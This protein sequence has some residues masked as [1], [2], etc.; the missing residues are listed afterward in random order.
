MACVRRIHQIFFRFGDRRLQ[1]YPI[2]VASLDA[3]R[4]MKGWKHRLWHEKG[5]ERLCRTKYPQLWDTYRRLKF[6]I[7]RVDLAKYMLAD[8]YGGVIVDLDVLPKCHVSEIVG[9]RPYVF[10][11]C[12][13]AHIIANDF[14]YVGQQGLPGFCEAFKQNLRRVNAIPVYRERKMRYIFNSS[15]PDFF[16]RFVKQ[17]G[18]DEYVVAISHRTFLDP[19]QR[20]RSVSPDRSQIE[21]IHH[22]SWAPQLRGADGN[23][24]AAPF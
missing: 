1:D 24:L 17:A 13:R 14:F 12:S 18:L 7:Q 3:W 2:F 16:S 19:K 8:A 23:I 9:D 6:G 11:R 22:L 10:D 21:V 15:G 5:V 4:N 20:H